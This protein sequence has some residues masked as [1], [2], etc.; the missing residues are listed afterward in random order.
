VTCLSI[1]QDISN[2]LSGFAYPNAVITSTDPQIK[3]L[4]ALLNKE[5][6]AQARRFNWQSLVKE[7][8]FT[9]L[10]A[11]S[12]GALTTIAPN[13]KYILNDTIWNRTRRLPLYGSLSAQEWAARKGGFF[14]GTFSQYRLK[15]G[16]INFL[17]TPTAG[18]SCAFEYQSSAWTTDGST[19][20]TAYRNDSDTSLLDEE[21]LKLGLIWRWRASKG[22]D[23][24]EDFNDYERAI[25]DAF[26]RDVPR[27]IIDLAPM[28]VSLASV[29]IPDGNFTR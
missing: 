12:Q 6:K 9:T 15:G 1:I 16:N 7:A 21:L 2:E 24:A 22:L 4:L 3:S 25:N 29:I 19:F 8:T 27:Q 28:P 26:S 18:D 5:G 23:Y 13:C 11:E 17:P 10:A 14:N 20:S